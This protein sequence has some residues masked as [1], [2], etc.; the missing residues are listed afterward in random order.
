MLSNNNQKTIIQA[1]NLLKVRFQLENKINSIN[2]NNNNSSKARMKKQI[3][4]K[5]YEKMQVSYD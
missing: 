5:K 2:K 4:H 3:I 1:V